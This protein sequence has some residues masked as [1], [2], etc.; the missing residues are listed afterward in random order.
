MLVA[1]LLQLEQGSFLIES[2]NR[3]SFLLDLEHSRSWQEGT[4]S[5]SESCPGPPER[6][7]RRRIHR[8]S[9]WGYLD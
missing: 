4:C 5:C 1:S 3:R 9:R 8:D 2:V 6:D 7:L